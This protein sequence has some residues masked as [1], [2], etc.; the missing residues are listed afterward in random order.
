LSQGELT[1][2]ETS[3]GNLMVISI[4]NIYVC[5]LMRFYSISEEGIREIKELGSLRHTNFEQVSVVDED[6]ILKPGNI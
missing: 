4:S 1:Y 3:R 5:L 6:D 2:F